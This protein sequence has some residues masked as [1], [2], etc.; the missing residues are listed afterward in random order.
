MEGGTGRDSECLCLESIVDYFTRDHKT[1]HNR[2][3][4]FDSRCQVNKCQPAF[5]PSTERRNYEQQNMDGHDH[6][7][8]VNTGTFM[9]KKSKG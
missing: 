7:T 6:P 9:S 2:R 3:A 8:Q 4:G 5:F 1:S